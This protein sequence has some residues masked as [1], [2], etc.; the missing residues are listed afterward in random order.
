M[1]EARNHASSALLI[2]RLG[3]RQSRAGHFGEEE[4]LAPV[5]IRTLPP[6][7]PRA[8]RYTAC[9]NPPSGLKNHR[10]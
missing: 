4:S 7:G 9:P 5:E 10:K 8:V 3:G 2:R 1:K 6:F